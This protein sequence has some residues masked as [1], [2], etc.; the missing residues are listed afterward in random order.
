[1]EKIELILENRLSAIK[2]EENDSYLVRKTEQTVKIRKLKINN[3]LKHALN[4]VVVSQIKKSNYPFLEIRR[5]KQNLVLWE[6]RNKSN[7][8]GIEHYKSSIFFLDEA[9][10]VIEA[11]L[12]PEALNFKKSIDQIISQYAYQKEDNPE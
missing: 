1:M 12:I 8:Q 6:D 3:Q 7:D 9:E 4:P 5:E 11:A 2:E 10:L